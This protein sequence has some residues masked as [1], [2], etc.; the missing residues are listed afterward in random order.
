M[1]DGKDFKK[2]TLSIGGMTCASCVAHVEEALKGVPGVK[3]AVV[4][5]ATGKASVEYDPTMASL[6]TMKKAVD[7]IGYE[8]VLSTTNLQVTGMT[9]ASCV[10]H[11]QK[12]V[13][14]LPGVFR[15]VVNL[16]SNS[17]RVEYEPGITSITDIKKAIR[18]LGYQASERSEG[19][20]G[21]DREKEARDREIKRQRTNLI[22]AGTLGT[23]VMLGMLQPYRLFPGIVPAWMNNK[24]FLFILTTPVVFGPGRQFFINSWNGLGVTPGR[25][26][27]GASARGRGD[28][29]ANTGKAWRHHYCFR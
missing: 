8:V 1:T 12:A 22:M 20:E 21:L 9:C 27:S 15:L 10:E 13:G 25:S 2:A 23:L 7:E 17:A 16:A 5:L 26:T 18:E 29:P 6:L 28:R 4:N 3:G 11:V 24:V 19:Q 14:N